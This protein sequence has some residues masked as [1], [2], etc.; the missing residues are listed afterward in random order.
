MSDFNSSKGLTFALTVIRLTTGFL[1]V[2]ALGLLL[3]KPTQDAPSS[4]TPITSVVV[5]HTQPRRPLI[6]TLLSFIAFTYLLD[7]LIVFIPCVVRKTCQSH[8]IEWRGVEL[9]NMLGFLA[10]VMLISVGVWKDKRGVDLW[11]RKR[12][13]ALAVIAIAFDIAYL[14]LLILSVRIFKS[15]CLHFQI[16]FPF[17]TL[18]CFM[19]INYD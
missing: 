13:K 11:S 8:L 9:A 5:A 15:E 7:E 17:A 6:L 14:V 3:T 12:L 2:Y 16:A 1:F 10:F 19:L 4:P 18:A